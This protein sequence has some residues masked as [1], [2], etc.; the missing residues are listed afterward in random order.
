MSDALR[1]FD[2]DLSRRVAVLVGAAVKTHGVPVTE[3]QAGEI[4]D[5]I[6]PQVLEARQQAW[7]AHIMD[8]GRQAAAQGV[9]LVPE[10]QKEYSRHALFK[11]VTEVSRLSPNSPDMW[12][13]VLDEQTQKLVKR[14]VALSASNRFDSQ[15]VRL[16]SE[17][18]GSRVAR[19][20]LAAGRDAVADSV[21]NGSARDKV[22]K[23]SRR[24]GYARVLSG[25]ES[26]AFCAMLASRGPVYSEDTVVRRRDGRRYHDNCDCVA[27]LVVHGQP[28]EGQAEYEAL[29]Q[30]WRT[31][32]GSKDQFKNWSRAV[33]GGKVDPRKYSPFTG[34][35]ETG[36]APPKLGSVK[37]GGSKNT[38]RS[39]VSKA[40]PT[41]D[42]NN[43]VRC[44]NAWGMRRAGYDIQAIPGQP[45][46]SAKR[47]TE[48]WRDSQGKRP[49]WKDARRDE[50][51]LKWPEIR[52]QLAD[53]PD[54]SWG[55]LRYTRDDFGQHVVAWEVR[56]GTLEII[57]SQYPDANNEIELENAVPDKTGWVNLTG[58]RPTI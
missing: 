44:V 19:H 15:V 16:I 13:D 45:G 24:V 37:R 3:G 52:Q 56:D 7:Q 48:T 49:N 27:V 6:Y 47:S 43:C 29:E 31:H 23:K 26:C 9:E 36:A 53:S 58:F 8:L 22:T 54:G 57:D 18:L 4:V 42:E 20:V 33:S 35:W 10:P 12:I 32:A 11:A 38:I 46:M 39:A 41:G 34:E 21:H 55:Y 51:A 30:A 2:A 40:N 25:K 1:R 28:W 17:Q 5:A 14:P 50:G